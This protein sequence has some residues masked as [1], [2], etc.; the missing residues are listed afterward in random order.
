L[1]K[2]TAILM[3]AGLLAALLLDPVAGAAAVAVELVKPA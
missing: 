2:R 1:H 3:Q